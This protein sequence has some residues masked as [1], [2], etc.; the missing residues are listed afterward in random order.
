MKAQASQGQ[1]NREL[2][3]DSVLEVNVM[4]NRLTIRLTP[5]ELETLHN[6]FS[7]AE[8]IENGDCFYMTGRT[9][10]DIKQ[11]RWTI[12]DAEAARKRNDDNG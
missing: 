4:D 2:P 6:L 11:L 10:D 7:L 1:N 9:E 5:N 12:E 8:R 3:G